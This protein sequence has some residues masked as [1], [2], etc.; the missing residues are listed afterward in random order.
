M[1]HF[2][3]FFTY[4]SLNIFLQVPVAD[5][6]ANQNCRM[7]LKK[8]CRPGPTPC[9][10][11]PYCNSCNQFR[12]TTGFGQCPDSQCNRYYPRPGNVMYNATQ[13]SLYP[14]MPSNQF[15]NNFGTRF[16]EDR[17]DVLN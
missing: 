1:F 15:Q 7:E 13:P 14:G 2:K 17:V 5:C 9:N 12:Q 8:R 6:R 10:N 4:F 11:S 16:H 3:F